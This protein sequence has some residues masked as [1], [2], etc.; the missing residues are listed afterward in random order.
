MSGGVTKVSWFRKDRR[1]LS[2]GRE[3]I[4]AGTTAKNAAILV[5]K[6][7]DSDFNNVVYVCTDGVRSQIAKTFSQIV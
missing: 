5:V 3:E 4:I 6:N 7:V 1:S 2:A